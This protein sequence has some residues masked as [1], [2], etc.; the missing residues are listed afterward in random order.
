MLP[1]SWTVSVK[2]PQAIDGMTLARNWHAYIRSIS[3]DRQT[4]GKVI[5]TRSTPIRMR[6]RVFM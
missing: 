3:T 6:M 1:F 2:K 5:L 4:Y